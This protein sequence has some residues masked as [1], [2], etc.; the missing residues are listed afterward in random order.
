MILFVQKISF[1][2]FPFRGKCRNDV[3]TKYIAAGPYLLYAN[4]YPAGAA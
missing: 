3:Q 1:L 4:D 2:P